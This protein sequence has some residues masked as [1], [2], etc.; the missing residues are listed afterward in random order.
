P[1]VADLGEHPGAGEC[2]EPWEAGDNAGVRVLV[3][4]CG[5][6]L[7]EVAG[8]G[9]GGVQVTE[10][11]RIG[12]LTDSTAAKTMASNRRE[13]TGEADPP[14]VLGEPRSAGLGG[15]SYLVADG[16][17]S[18]QGAAVPVAGSESFAARRAGC[19]RSVGE[20]SGACFAATLAWA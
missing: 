5:D 10:Q 1:V 20:A 19:W 3:K 4:R 8:A 13:A 18:R 2:A 15:V 12:R 9:A 11:G 17:Q 14:T 7:L 6:C 16:N